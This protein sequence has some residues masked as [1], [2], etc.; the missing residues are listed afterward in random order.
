MIIGIVCNRGIVYFEYKQER[1]SNISLA[2]QRMD[3]RIGISSKILK[4][5]IHQGDRKIDALIE[6]EINKKKSK[7]FV[8]IKDTILLDTINSKRRMMKHLLIG[9][10][11]TVKPINDACH[12]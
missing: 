12:L 9:Y 6:L 4:Q 5:R 8:E 3:D 11:D 1:N 7:Y 2:T 10:T